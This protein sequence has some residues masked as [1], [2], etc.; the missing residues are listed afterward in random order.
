[1]VA[2]VSRD[3]ATASATPPGSPPTRVRSLASTAT[4]VPP[5]RATPT[6][7]WARAGASLTP[8]PAIATTWPAC[9]RRR[10]SAALPSG[11]SSAANPSTPSS[12]AT[13]AAVA[14][15]VPGEH[16]RLQAELPEPLHGRPDPAGDDPAA[17]GRQPGR[18]DQ[19]LAPA[20]PPGH[21]LAGQAGER[22]DGGA[23]QP[24]LL[25]PLGHGPG[26]RVLGGVL[27][28]GRQGQQLGGGGAVIGGPPPPGPS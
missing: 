3:R 27:E 24:A 25:G 12:A 1:M 21:A 18:P 8:S 10:T 23:G 15:W 9:W 13:V 19:Q 6:S 7:A 4:S 11:D 28:A 14:W 5:P 26:H 22:L 20:D 2:W 16:D 17:P